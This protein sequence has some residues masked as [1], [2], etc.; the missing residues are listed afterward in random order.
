[1]KLSELFGRAELQYP[2]ALGDMEIEYKLD[3]PDTGIGTS[4]S[5]II[6]VSLKRCL[7]VLLVFFTALIPLF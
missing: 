6:P 7:S 3:F 1:M 2:P 5:I 4:L